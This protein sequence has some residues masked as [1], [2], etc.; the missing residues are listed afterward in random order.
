MAASQYKKCR[1]GRRNYIENWAGQ[2]AREEG[3]ELGSKGNAERISRVINEISDFHNRYGNLGST[4][5]FGPRSAG[6]KPYS[7][8]RKDLQEHVEAHES[9]P[10]AR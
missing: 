1:R 10:D 9:A 7:N 5:R 3:G 4:I 6:L 8:P 2:V